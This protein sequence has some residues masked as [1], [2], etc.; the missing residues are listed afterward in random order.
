MPDVEGYRPS[1]YSNNLATY[2]T[3]AACKVASYV[4]DKVCICEGLQH[5]ALHLSGHWYFHLQCSLLIAHEDHKCLGEEYIPMARISMFLKF[6]C[7]FSI[8]VLHFKSCINC[9]VCHEFYSLVIIAF[10]EHT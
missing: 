7:L 1:S 4:E 9:T 3:L 2:I 6:L 8:V 10:L 5:R